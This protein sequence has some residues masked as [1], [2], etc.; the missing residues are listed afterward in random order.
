MGHK[1]L[2]SNRKKS[3]KIHDSSFFF[4]FLSLYG[5][6]K[7]VVTHPASTLPSGIKEV[8]TTILFFASPNP[9]WCQTKQKPHEEAFY[10]RPNSD[11]IQGR[12][13][14]GMLWWPPK[15]QNDLKK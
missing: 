8:S 14:L 12:M 5:A 9:F 10:F 3:E 6:L 11:V 13:D 1:T 15:I 4:F 2:H 7:N